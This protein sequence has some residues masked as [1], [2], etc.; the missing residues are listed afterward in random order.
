MMLFDLVDAASVGCV[1]T[2]RLA[3]G[4]WGGT[5]KRFRRMLPVN[6]LMR[7]KHLRASPYS[8]RSFLDRVYRWLPG[9]AQAL[10]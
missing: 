2:H 5:A 6:T 3:G 8:L 4:S 9:D 1:M 7:R 10:R